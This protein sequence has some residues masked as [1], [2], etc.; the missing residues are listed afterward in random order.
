MAQ[1]K[2]GTLTLVAI[3]IA[4]FAAVMCQSSDTTMTAAS[5]PTTVAMTM[6]SQTGTV[7]TVTTTRNTVKSAASALSTSGGLALLTLALALFSLH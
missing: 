5:N 6:T 7:A 2:T 3:F 4:L 1:S